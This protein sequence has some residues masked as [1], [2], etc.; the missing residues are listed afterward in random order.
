M[1]KK[2]RLYERTLDHQSAKFRQARK[3][4]DRDFIR[5]LEREQEITWDLTDQLFNITLLWETVVA[6]IHTNGFEH[7]CVFWQAIILKTSFC[8]FPSILE[9]LFFTQ[10]STP[11]RIFPRAG[12]DENASAR[13]IRES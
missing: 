8:K 1:P 5:H 4:F 7:F 9:T 13:E 11:T 6:S 3:F 12:A 2:P 10:H